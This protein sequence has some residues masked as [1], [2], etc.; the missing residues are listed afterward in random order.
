MHGVPGASND[1][2]DPLS[3]TKVTDSLLTPDIF[4]HPGAASPRKTGCFL[5]NMKSHL[6][7]VE[8]S[9]ESQLPPF[10]LFGGKLLEP[11]P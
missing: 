11:N 4:P 1:V 3:L 8:S 6:V 2:C 7:S 5:Y 9:G 10:F